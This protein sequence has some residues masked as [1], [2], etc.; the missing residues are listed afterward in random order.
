MS[1]LGFGDTIHKLAIFLS[2]Q[3]LLSDKNVSSEEENDHKTK[4]SKSMSW[5]L[6]LKNN[7]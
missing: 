1:H 5:K 4:T 6:L 2:S 3:K 7:N